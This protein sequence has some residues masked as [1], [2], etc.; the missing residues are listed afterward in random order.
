MTKRFT[1]T[2]EFDPEAQTNRYSAMCFPSP[3]GDTKNV[4]AIL[5]NIADKLEESD[6]PKKA[7]PK[8]AREVLIAAIARAS[9][10]KPNPGGL[11]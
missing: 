1:V 11:K 8:A 9:E 10:L 2:I 3:D 6:R 5:R 4:V 7:D